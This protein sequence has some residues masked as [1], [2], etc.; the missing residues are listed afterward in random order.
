MPAI[1]GDAGPRRFADASRRLLRSTVF[2]ALDALAAERPWTAI[3]MAEIA[4]A[5]GVS[6]QTLYNEFGSR[7]DLAQAYVLWASEQFLVQIEEVVAARSDDLGGALED[8]FRVFLELAAEHPLVRALEATTG[9]EGLHALVASSAG[10]PVLLTSTD[11]LTDFVLRNWPELPQA[12]TRLV[13]ELLVRLAISH[14]TVP[15]VPPAKAAEQVGTVLGPFL[16]EVRAALAAG[17]GDV[18]RSGW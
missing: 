4:R 15:T 5:A 18:A 1:D 7:D 3:T 17:P 9:A 11:R 13:C 6:R 14:A 16:A 8:A 2:E 12:E 10:L